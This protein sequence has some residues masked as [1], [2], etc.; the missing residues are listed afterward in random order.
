VLPRAAQGD[1]TGGA[2][3]YRLAFPA[4]GDVRSR[5]SAAIDEFTDH[6]DR[7]LMKAISFSRHAVS[8]GLRG[9]SGPPGEEQVGFDAFLLE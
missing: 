6:S 5:C 4:G 7:I 2:N 9:S 8:A 1:R 3:E